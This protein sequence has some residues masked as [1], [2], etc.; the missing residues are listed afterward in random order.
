MG[1]AASSATVLI[2][3]MQAEVYRKEH[4]AIEQQ[5]WL[6]KSVRILEY[7]ATSE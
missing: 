3:A 1:E 5:N 7:S 6:P 2:D 4:L